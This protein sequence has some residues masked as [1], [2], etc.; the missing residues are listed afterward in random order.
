MSIIQTF[1][2]IVDNKAYR[3]SS[4]D[5]AIFENGNIQS[6]FGFDNSD[7]IE[8]IL[9]DANDNQLPQGESQQLVRYITLNSDNI[10]DYFLIAKGT[11]FKAFEFPEYFIDVERLILEA[12][13]SNGIF[14]TQITLLN[15]RVGFERNHDKLWIKEISP[16]RLEVK[17]LPLKTEESK[18]TDLEER[19]DIMVEGG[20]FRSDIIS[21]VP[22]L[23][24]SINP[25]EVKNFIITKYTE[26]YD[27]FVKE[28][29]ITDF[30]ILINTIH[31]K[32]IEAAKYEFS[33]RISDIIDINY[34]KKREEPPILKLSLDDVISIIENILKGCIDYYLPKQNIEQAEYDIKTDIVTLEFDEDTDGNQSVIIKPIKII[35]TPT[36]IISPRNP[37]NSIK[38]DVIPSDEFVHSDRSGRI[39][40][41]PDRIDTLDNYYG[42]LTSDKL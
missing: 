10:R 8:F 35:D 37:I 29:S 9:F 18:H 2:E 38:D 27:M 32:F 30:D 16:S 1:K 25:S 4:K 3:I 20:G 28:F 41:N 33:N 15:K 17:L 40:Y 24:E 23:L 13:Y 31:T 22:S 21:H 34:G 7:M 36:P 39:S 19:F 12:G 26:W 42:D 6:F 11:T 5:R 14:K